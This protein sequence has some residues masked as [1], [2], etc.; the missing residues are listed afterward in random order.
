M[1]WYLLFTNS[2]AK[3]TPNRCQLLSHTTLPS[4]RATPFSFS[5]FSSTG[6][7]REFFLCQ[8]WSLSTFPLFRF[9]RCTLSLYLCCGWTG[10]SRLGTRSLSFFFLHLVLFPSSTSSSLFSLLSPSKQRMLFFSSK[11]Q[12]S[13]PPLARIPSFPHRNHPPLW[14]PSSS[15]LGRL[16]PRSSLDDSE[17]NFSADAHALRTEKFFACLCVI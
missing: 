1:V 15:R 10:D 3:H 5:P 12:S 2:P 7:E 6:K 9:G 8:E 16:P 11:V 14:E 17:P 13:I 4:D